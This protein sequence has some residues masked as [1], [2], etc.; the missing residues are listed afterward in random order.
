MNYQPPLISYFL[1]HP[2]KT[3]LLIVVFSVAAV[4]GHGM[5]ISSVI[6]LLLIGLLPLQ[7]SMSLSTQ[8]Q[9]NKL[10]YES[11]P[12]IDKA[13]LLGI[14]IP[15]QAPALRNV[16]FFSAEQM[17]DWMSR[18]AGLRGMIYLI[19][20]ILALLDLYQI[21]HTWSG[22]QDTSLILLPILLAGFYLWRSRT[23]YQLWRLAEQQQ[24]LVGSAIMGAQSATVFSAYLPTSDAEQPP[25]P[26]LSALLDPDVH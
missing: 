19:G 9:Q 21:F 2:L 17:R 15:Y 18:Q 6:W 3:I 24:W 16:Y 7:L 12:G 23:Y 11:C 10:L 20:V 1:A 5:L 13:Y 25:V 8:H 14:A 22:L 26:Y 4:Q